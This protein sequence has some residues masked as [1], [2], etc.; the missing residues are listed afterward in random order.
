MK[1]NSSSI[2]GYKKSKIIFTLSMV[3]AIFIFLSQVI[4]VYQYPLVGGIFELL[5]LPVFS[6]L[7]ILPIL[8]FIFL[9]KE[10]F[11]LSSLYIYSFLINVMTV[12]C[13]IFR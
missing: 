4:N 10:K 2:T 9:L 12:L 11:S 8:S 5:W 1:N 7:F 3:V 6:L 13:L